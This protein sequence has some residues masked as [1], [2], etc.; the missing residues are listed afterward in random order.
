MDEQTQM[1][2][3]AKQLLN[4]DRE[5]IIWSEVMREKG[6]GGVKKEEG[7]SKSIPLPGSL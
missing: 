2:E 3:N 5:R 7:H 6:Q 4:W 1:K